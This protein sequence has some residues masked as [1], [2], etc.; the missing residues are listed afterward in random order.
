[1][2]SV[3]Y[4]LIA[5]VAARAA[6]SLL[7]AQQAAVEKSTTGLDPSSAA[8]FEQHIQ[9]I[10]QTRCLACHDGESKVSKLDLT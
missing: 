7:F 2:T 9:P 4:I 1:M 3:R 8:Y 5:L 6:A 10:F